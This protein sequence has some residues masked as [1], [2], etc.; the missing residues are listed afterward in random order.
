MLPIND[1]YRHN[2]FFKKCFQKNLD[3]VL[4]KGWF[5]LGSEVTNFE[6]EFA[7]YCGTYFCK[8]VAN[9]TEALEIALR[10]LGIK[11]NDRVITVAN[12]G[13]YSSTALNSIGA[14]PVYVDIDHENMLISI[15]SLLSALKNDISCII[16][17]HLYGHAVK[18]DE[19]IQISNKY[20]IPI[21]EDCA[22][23]H[24]ALFKG[25]RVGSFGKL[26]C[27]SF[28][29][30]KNLG[31]LGDGGAIVTNDSDLAERIAKLRQY[32][33]G[34]KYYSRING[35]RNSRMD[36]LQASFLRAKLPFLDSWNARRLAICKQYIEGITHPLV[37][38][39]KISE[40]SY[41]GHL[42]VIRSTYRD[43]LQMHLKCKEIMADIHYPIPDYRQPCWVSLYENTAL[44]ET[45]LSCAEVLT[46]PCFPEMSDS[47]IDK[48]IS[49]IN[50]WTTP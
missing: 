12:A 42:F 24:G 11:E 21:V 34:K 25:K 50:E 44:K 6:H 10:A 1:L 45:E 22:Q 49:A 43:S 35:G 4:Q 38:M 14:K 30:T 2:I 17:T 32:G 39:P 46:L 16:V 29:P 40:S 41:V 20:N 9:G 27:F 26:G 19:I 18:I 13:G 31:A 5:I 37:R 7:R 15:P 36:E 48:V 33:W 47:E 8:A 23:A 3:L 28:Y